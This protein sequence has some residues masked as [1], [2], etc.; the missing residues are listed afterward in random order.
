MVTV[1]DFVRLSLLVVKRRAIVRAEG[2]RFNVSASALSA[3]FRRYA[4]A[5]RHGLIGD[6]RGRGLACGV[7]LV[8]NNNRREPA[9][10]EAAKL[11]YRAYELG[12]VLYYVGMNSNV[13]E[14]TPPLTIENHEIDKALELLDRAFADV[15]AGTVPDP[16][17]LQFSG[18]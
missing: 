12:L 7:E 5:E 8:R 6:V 2:M 1:A 16:S 10:T 4:L 11:V 3:R 18:W 14:M 9:G 15:A 13:L 17:T